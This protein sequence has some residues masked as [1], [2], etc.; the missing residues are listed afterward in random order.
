[1]TVDLAHALELLSGHDPADPQ[2]FAAPHRHAGS[3]VDALGRGVRGLVI[4]VP[5][6]EWTDASDPVQR[7]GRAAL[8]ALEKEGAK[9]VP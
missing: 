5:E 4:G 2:T 1:S 9:L 6:S 7:A 8:A 3:F